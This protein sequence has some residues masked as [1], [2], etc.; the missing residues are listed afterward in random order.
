MAK[1]QEAGPVKKM[2]LHTGY[3]ENEDGSLSIA[4]RYTDEYKA[5]A[6]EEQAISDL[7]SHVMQHCAR[8]QTK[9]NSQRNRLWDELATDIGLKFDDFDYSVSIRDGKLIKRAK[10][11]TAMGKTASLTNEESK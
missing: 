9:V 5:L 6:A 3:W 4:S 7:L 10:P 2:G 1:K 8:M 11:D